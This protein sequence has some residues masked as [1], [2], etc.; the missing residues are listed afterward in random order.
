M[1]RII[2]EKEPIR[3]STRF[4]QLVAADVRRLTSNPAIRNPRSAIAA[5]LDWIVLKC[6]EKNRARRYETANGLAM[7][8]QRY[9]SN[10]PVAARPPSAAYK[11]QKAWQRNKLA[12]IAAAVVALAL[13]SGIGVSTWQAVRAT[14]SRSVAHRTGKTKRGS[15]RKAAR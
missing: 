8:L 5:D 10:E 7:D 2:K 14:R 15:T 11:I 4:T 6:L 1:R 9:L 3:P 13:I 12:F